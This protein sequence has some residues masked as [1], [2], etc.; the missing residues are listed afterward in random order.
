MKIGMLRRVT[1]LE[2]PSLGGFFG[3]FFLT[4]KQGLKDASVLQMETKG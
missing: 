1:E 3:F 2:K 4:V